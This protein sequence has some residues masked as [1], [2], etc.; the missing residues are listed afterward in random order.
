MTEFEQIMEFIAT[1]LLLAGI[2][3]GFWL[4]LNAVFRTPASTRTET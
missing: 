3:F 1:P 4:L 2:A